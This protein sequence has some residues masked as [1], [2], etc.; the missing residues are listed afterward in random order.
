VLPYSFIHIVVNEHQIMPCGNTGFSKWMVDGIGGQA[1]KVPLSC[2]AMQTTFMKPLGPA[3]LYPMKP[4]CAGCGY[5]Q[6]R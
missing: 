5:I 4:S 3:D 6:V 1:A 2:I